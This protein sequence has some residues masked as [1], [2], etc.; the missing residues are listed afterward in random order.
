MSEPKFSSAS[1]P[2]LAALGTA[3][4]VATVA[5]PAEATISVSIDD[6]AKQ[7]TSIV[8]V[9]MLE[10]TSTWEGEH[11]V[12]TTRLRVERVIAGSG[13]G[14]EVSV[15]TC[16]GV[17]GNIGE[18]VEGEATFSPNVSSIV[19][20]KQRA[21]DGVFVVAGGAQ[22]QLVVLKDARTAREVVRVLGTGVLLPRPQRVPLAPPI[23]SPLLT[24][25]DGRDADDVSS[26]AASAWG[27]THAR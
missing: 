27:R 11:I 26:E 22:G 12:T 7:S 21:A 14:S 8:R 25:F 3:L 6:V 16:G 13:S 15:R 2:W 18:R 17:V 5:S 10:Q 23:A 24:S 1:L 20:L 19:F 9:T 4:F